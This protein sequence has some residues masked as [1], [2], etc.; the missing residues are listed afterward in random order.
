MNKIDEVISTQILNVFLLT[1][2]NLEE[3]PR[4]YLEYPQENNC[5]VEII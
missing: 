1:N 5:E 4:K 3:L 2:N